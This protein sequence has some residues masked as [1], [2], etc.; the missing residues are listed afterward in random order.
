[1]NNSVQALNS[2]FV[3]MIC[4]AFGGFSAIVCAPIPANI[5]R[6]T[7]S[8]IELTTH[9]SIF[10]VLLA[11]RTQIIMACNGIIDPQQHTKKRADNDVEATPLAVNIVIRVIFDGE[12]IP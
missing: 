10:D 5:M 7:H 9:T 6:I 11:M 2:T 12:K 4:L 3:E 8:K 1:M